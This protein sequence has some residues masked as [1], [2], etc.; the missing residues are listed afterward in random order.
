MGLL[1]GHYAPHAFS[2]L[3]FTRFGG[4]SAILVL[5]RSLSRRGFSPIRFRSDFLITNGKRNADTPLTIRQQIY[6]LARLA[7]YSG[8]GYKTAMGLGQVRLLARG[9]K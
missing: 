9:A 1:T 7:F 3:I 8:V 5:S 4:S 2:Q 6:L